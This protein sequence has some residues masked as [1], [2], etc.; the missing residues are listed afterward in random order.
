M[1]LL[2][3]MAVTSII[4]L[5]LLNITAEALES[6]RLSEQRTRAARQ[7]KEVIDKLATDFESFQVRSG[8]KFEW[9]YASRDSKVRETGPSGDAVQLGFFTLS[10]ARC[11]IGE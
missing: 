10:F 6:W 9:L 4:V 1:E 7:A 5:L 3:A 2:V 8:N 11:R